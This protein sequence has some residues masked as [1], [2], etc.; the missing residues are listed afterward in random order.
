MS[1][2]P[3]RSQDQFIVR[4]PEGMR[5][6]LKELADE[7]RR[8]MNA[9]MVMALTAWLDDADYHRHLATTVDDL[10]YPK[11]GDTIDGEVVPEPTI[12]FINTPADVDA[13]VER[14]TRETAARMRAEMLKMLKTDK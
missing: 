9:E 2:A 10:P 3:S 7:N 14:F 5:D 12:G 11:P 6:R 4:L 1:K 8:S 13:A